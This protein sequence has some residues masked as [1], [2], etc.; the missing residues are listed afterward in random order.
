MPPLTQ[1]ERSIA[2]LLAEISL[3]QLQAELLKRWAKSPG[4]TLRENY[5]AHENLRELA[6]NLYELADLRL[7]KIIRV[8]KKNKK[9]PIDDAHYLDVE[10]AFR[11][12]LKAFAPG[13]AHRY[14]FKPRKLVEG[15]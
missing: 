14:K 5:E 9:A 10:D 4:A 8:W 11:G 12:Q 6:K 15:E 3:P 13:F 1:R 2:K 7:K